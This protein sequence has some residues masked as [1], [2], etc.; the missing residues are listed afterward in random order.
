M[1]HICLIAFLQLL[2][3]L[4]AATKPSDPPARQEGSVRLTVYCPRFQ[5]EMG[6]TLDVIVEVRNDG[7]AAM[8][9][10]SF[11]SLHRVP[12]EVP[13]R[14][15]EALKEMVEFAKGEEGHLSIAL[16]V[17]ADTPLRMFAFLN[18]NPKR[19]VTVAPKSSHFFKVTIPKDAFAVGRCAVSASGDKGIVGS[20]AVELKCVKKPE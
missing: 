6:Q 19:V 9:L 12:D 1:H 7:P 17:P 18:G 8:D 3:C 4:Q 10:S 11:F 20:A 13:G 14:P 2:V 5:V 16:A 15:K